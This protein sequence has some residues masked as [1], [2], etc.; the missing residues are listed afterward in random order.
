M[1]IFKIQSAVGQL[2]REYLTQEKFVEIHTPKLQGAATESG[3]S[4]F[5]VAYF[6]RK[7]ERFSSSRSTAA[8]RLTFSSGPAFLAQSPQLAKQMCIAG[9]MERVFEIAPGQSLL[10]AA[11]PMA[12]AG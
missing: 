6:D 7:Q 5:K 4:V 1:A 12:L 8:D 11:S 3:A 2:F 9:D 10:R